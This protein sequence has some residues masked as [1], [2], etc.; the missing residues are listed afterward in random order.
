MLRRTMSSSDRLRLGLEDLLGDL[1]YARR[2]GNLGRLA[3]LVYCEL[4]RWARQAD[5]PRLASHA[6]GMF[7]RAPYFDRASFLAEVDSLIAEAN[8]ALALLPGSASSAG[9]TSTADLARTLR[10]KT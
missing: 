6:N 8:D 4:R 3:L 10:S 2:T 9:T 7:L 1:S 5:M